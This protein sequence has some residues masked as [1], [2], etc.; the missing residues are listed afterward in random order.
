MRPV[1][2]AE[3]LGMLCDGRHRLAGKKAVAP[4]HRL[5][6]AGEAASRLVYEGP[7]WQARDAEDSGGGRDL[8]VPCPGRVFDGAHMRP[9]AEAVWPWYDHEECVRSPP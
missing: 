2:V 5:L 6:A 8:L 7:L 3:R 4:T 1:G 9:G